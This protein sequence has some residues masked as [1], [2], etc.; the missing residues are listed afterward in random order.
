MHDGVHTVVFQQGAYQFPIAR[1]SDNQFPVKYRIGETVEVLRE[2][3][4]PFDLVFNDIEKHG[5]P[6]SLPVIREK[7]RP[8]GILIVDNALWHGR[9]FDSEDRSS[10]TRGVREVTRLLATDPGWLTTLVPV[11]DGLLI[12]YKR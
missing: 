2:T 3:D 12:A 4:G 1:I 11:R 7:L 10:A 9:I 5:Y 8:G 6:A